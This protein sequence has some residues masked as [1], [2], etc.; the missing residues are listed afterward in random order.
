M[1]L[2]TTSSCYFLLEKSVSHITAFYP[3]FVIK[4]AVGDASKIPLLF[5]LYSIDSDFS[6]HA[7]DDEVTQLSP[8]L[9][10]DKSLLSDYSQSGTSSNGSK[11]NGSYLASLMQY[12]RDAFYD[13]DTPIWEHVQKVHI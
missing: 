6:S 13:A 8:P 11:S 3:V 7:D 5:P 4:L 2:T 12:H 1:D 10:G 9:A